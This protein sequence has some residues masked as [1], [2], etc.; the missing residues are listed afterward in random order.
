MKLNRET[1]AYLLGAG[2][3]LVSLVVPPAAQAALATLATGLAG[4]HVAW[5]GLHDTVVQTQAAHR[6]TPNIHLLMILAAL[7]ALAIGSPTE[8]ALLILI[9]AG[10]HFLEEYAENKSRSAIT[11]LMAMAPNN[12]RRYTAGGRVEVVAVDDLAVGDRLLIQNGAQIPIDGTILTGTGAINEAA[13]SGEAIPRE[14]G[15]GDPVFAGT[16]NGNHPFDMTVTKAASDTVFAQ[17]IRL[18]A[19]AQNTPTQTASMIQR[20]EPRYVR[21]VLAALPLVLLAGPLGFGWSWATSWYRTIGFLVAASP[22]ALA[23]SAVPATLAGITTLAKNGVLFKGGR[24]LANL[25]QLKA[26]AFDKTGTL[27]AGHPSVTDVRF[28]AAVVEAELLPVIVAMER[29]SNHPLA[30]AIVAHFPTV[31]PCDVTVHSQLG[32]GLSATVAGHQFIIGKPARFAPVPAAW[33]AQVAALTHQGKTVILIARDG[34]VVGLIALLDAPKPSAKGAI[35]YLKAHGVTPVMITGD[36]QPTGAAV[37]ASLGIDTVYA[38]VMPTQKAS[39]ISRLQA[40][41]A[42]LAMVGDGVND[43]PALASAEVGIAMG[44][45]TDVAIDVADVVLVDNDLARLAFAH[46]V[47]RKLDRIVRENLVF[48]MSVVVLLV[49]L[50]ALQLTNI[51]WGVVLHEGSTLLVILNGLRLLHMRRES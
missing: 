26:I 43:A 16:L 50:N 17:I 46:R 1:T 39:V 27:T 34:V 41:F 21:L 9:F 5:E 48:A 15:P 28:S 33:Q 4:Y 38:N 23:A 29:Q 45:G 3:F 8:A 47:S 25:K 6:F 37:G 22:C 10:A 30:A 42:P 14:K 11:A 36:A 18:V 13:I 31:P 24:Y 7:G 49:G 2:T 40:H 35:D 19:A 12:A 20:F 32:Q 51:A 44:A